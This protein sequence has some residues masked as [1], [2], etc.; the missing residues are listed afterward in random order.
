MP[1]DQ[2]YVFIFYSMPIY[3]A[4]MR[5]LVNVGVVWKQAWDILK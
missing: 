2:D 3:K 4:Y 1:L 5:Q